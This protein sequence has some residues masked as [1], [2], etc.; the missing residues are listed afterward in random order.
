M[1]VL[2]EYELYNYDPHILWL[3]GLAFGVGTVLGDHAESA[4]KRLIGISPGRPLPFFDQYDFMAVSIPLA[5]P[6]TCWIGWE[7][8]A[9]LM[10]FFIPWY[11]IGN[12]IGWWR[13][14]RDTWF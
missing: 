9:L 10:G 11:V 2:R 1:P 6:L 13:G 7:R 14:D 12:L 5:I 8:L 4:G 3:I